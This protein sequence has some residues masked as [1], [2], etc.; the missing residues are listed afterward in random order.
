LDGRGG[1]VD[2]N[3]FLTTEDIKK[4]LSFE[5]QVEQMFITS[6]QKSNKTTVGILRA[7]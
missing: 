3:K 1:K 2:F 4:R 7:V 6:C 5:K